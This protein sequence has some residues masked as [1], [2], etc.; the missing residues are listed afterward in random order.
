MTRMTRLGIGIAMAAAIAGCIDPQDRR[1]GTRL[2][3]EVTASR[4]DWSFTNDHKLIAVE[5]QT[6]YLLPH[7][8]NIWC[9]EVDGQLYIGARDPETKRWPGWADRDPN[10]RL[11]IGNQTFEVRLVPLE[12]QE[13][14]ERIQSA[15]ATKYDLPPRSDEPPPIRYWSI[16]ARS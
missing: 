4:S 5:V 9:A 10:V 6:P 13:R 11:G 7:S 12:D 14:V 3:G 8:V 16:E 15:Y 2:T 1:P